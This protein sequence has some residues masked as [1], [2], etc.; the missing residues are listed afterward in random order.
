MTSVGPS[1]SIHCTWWAA[2]VVGVDGDDRQ[3]GQRVDPQPVEHEAGELGEP[4]DVDVGSGLVVHV[5][6]HEVLIGR[7]LVGRSP[8]AAAGAAAPGATAGGALV[9]RLGGVPPAVGVDDVGHQ[10]VAHDVLR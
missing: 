9:G 8:A 10:P 4:V 5:D 6:A 1:S 3:L 7:L 2:I